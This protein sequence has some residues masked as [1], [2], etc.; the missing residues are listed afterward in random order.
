MKVEQLMSR[1]VK[2]CQA[3]EM[4]NRAAQLMWENDCGCVPVVD[5]DG[6]AVGMI[7]DRDVCMAAYTQGRLLDAL[8]V[9]SAMDSIVGHRVA[10][11]CVHQFVTDV[12]AY[13]RTTIRT[14]LAG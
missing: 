12:A 14:G 5:E 11:A 4:L 13:L 10:E 1:D 8:P 2:T 7:T 6:R 9:A 3:T